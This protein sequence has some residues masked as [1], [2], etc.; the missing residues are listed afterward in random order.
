M[1]LHIFP[2]GFPFK[3]PKCKCDLGF[4]SWAVLYAYIP[5]SAHFNPEDRGGTTSETLV[6]SRHTTQCSYPESKDFYVE[7]EVE[8]R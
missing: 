6:C 2:L 8:L 3:L 4:V 7:V 5:L 1:G